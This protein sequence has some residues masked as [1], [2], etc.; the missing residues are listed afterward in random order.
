VTYEYLGDF[1][2]A[3]TMMS[4]YLTE[5]PDDEEAKR[6]NEFLATR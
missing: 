2:R 5:H 6:E 3:K 1:D 4:D